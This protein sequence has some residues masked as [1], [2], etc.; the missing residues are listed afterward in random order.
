MLLWVGTNAVAGGLGSY[1]GY[2]VV[3]RDLTRNDESTSARGDS[4]PAPREG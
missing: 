1:T 4:T 3:R 2:T